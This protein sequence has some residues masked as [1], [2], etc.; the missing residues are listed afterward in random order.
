[1]AQNQLCNRQE[2]EHL[3]AARDHQEELLTLPQSCALAASCKVKGLPHGQLRNVF[4][5]LQQ[6]STEPCSTD[7]QC[8]STVKID[9][10]VGLLAIIM[11]GPATL[12]AS[13]KIAYAEAH[14]ALRCCRSTMALMLW[15]TDALQWAYST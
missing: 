5:D 4:I 14:A 10:C 8:L 1:M 15:M 2:N 7:G 9:M 11:T 12:S 3:R 6:H 13:K